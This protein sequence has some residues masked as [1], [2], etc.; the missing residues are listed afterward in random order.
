MESY[1]L[2]SFHFATC[3]NFRLRVTRDRA[4]ELPAV[5]VPVDYHR[6]N[7]RIIKIFFLLSF[8]LRIGFSTIIIIITNTHHFPNS[9]FC[10][11]HRDNHHYYRISMNSNSMSMTSY[12]YSFVDVSYLKFFPVTSEYPNCVRGILNRSRD[13]F[14]YCNYP[15]N[16]SR[17]CHCLNKQTNN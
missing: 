14:E 16:S 12:R 17:F 2:Y 13:P 9:A 7:L 4:A 8:H 10:D 11:R 1:H 15:L 5:P 6:L 3:A